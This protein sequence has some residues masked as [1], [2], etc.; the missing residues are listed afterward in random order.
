MNDPYLQ[1][2]V[3]DANAARR[4]AQ[5]WKKEAKHCLGA[6]EIMDEWATDD[7]ARIAELERALRAA[8][9]DGVVASYPGRVPEESVRHAQ[10]IGL[11]TFIAAMMEEL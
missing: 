5:A 9:R 7:G 10:K 1:G 4:W 3:A 2:S 8:I 11:E 6:L